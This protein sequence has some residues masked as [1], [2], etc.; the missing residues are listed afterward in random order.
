MRF[1]S[2]RFWS[3]IGCSCLIGAALWSTLSPNAQATVTVTL[4]NTNNGLQGLSG[5][6]PTFNFPATGG[7]TTGGVPGGA[8]AGSLNGSVING[9]TPVVLNDGGANAQQ[10]QF[11]VSSNASF[12]ATPTTTPILLIT[13][14]GVTGTT[15]APVPLTF[16]GGIPMWVNPGG[17]PANLAHAVQFVP[18]SPITVG[19]NMQTLCNDFINTEGSGTALGCDTTNLLAPSGGGTTG[20]LAPWASFTLTFGV[21]NFPNGTTGFPV[22]FP[23]PSSPV[24]SQQVTLNFN[25]EGPP[26]STTTPPAT[27]T[28]PG[29]T[30][31]LAGSYFPGDQQITVNANAVT[32]GVFNM[33]NALSGAPDLGPSSIEVMGQ[34]QT[35][36]SGFVPLDPSIATYQGKTPGVTLSINQLIAPGPGQIVTGFENSTDAGTGSEPYAVGFLAV[37]QYGFLVD[38][39]QATAGGVPPNPAVPPYCAYPNALETSQI[40]G[41]LNASKCFIATATFRSV[42][43]PPLVLL[44]DFR[45][46]F[47]EHFVLGRSFVH[48]YYRWSPGAADWLVENPVFRFPVFLALIPLQ[49]LAWLILNPGFLTLV[50]ML[51]LSVLGYGVSFRFT[52]R[53]LAE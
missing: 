35:P 23:S 8:G 49:I 36:G 38:N 28:A 47:L 51:G 2:A 12:A 46:R 4:L 50:F 1:K 27:V 52:K 53:E 41:F 20:T 22:P 26:S 10:V 31:S 9:V 30:C 34:L 32:P 17:T 14:A 24:D 16:V 7:T 19:L 42:D 18:N 44:R 21:Y 39:N 5:I 37:D 40:L 3:S 13:V 33:A 6:I 25:S 48:W 29:L 43:S 11:S 15:V 45:G